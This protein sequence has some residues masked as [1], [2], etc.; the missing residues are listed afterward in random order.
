MPLCSVGMVA[1]GIQVG[2]EW[3]MR[4]GSRTSHHL[5]ELL[6]M[7]T[8]VQFV[9]KDDSWVWKLSK[10]GGYSVKCARQIID[11]S[12]LATGQQV[13][14]WCRIVPAKVNIMCWRAIQNRL[15]TRSQLAVKGIDI[16]SVLCPSCLVAIED[17]QH[18]FFKCD[19]AVEVWKKVAS[20]LDLQIPAIDDISMLLDWAEASIS[21]AK[22]RKVVGAIIY[23]TI[24]MLW[25]FR[26]SIVFQDPKMK[27]SHIYDNIVIHSFDWCMNRCGKGSR[28]G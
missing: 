15:P 22:K 5:H 20:W 25:R 18:V 11:N 8:N 13:T 2:Y 9:D 24:W 10:D 16:P 6:E 23:T 28:V 1:Y 3:P 21:D 19:V 27:K 17:V 26:N 7:L 4:E 12:L 14:R